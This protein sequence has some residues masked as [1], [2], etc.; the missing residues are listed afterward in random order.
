MKESI[1]KDMDDYIQ[2]LEDEDE[3]NLKVCYLNQIK[4]TNW[5]FFKA[6]KKKKKKDENAPAGTEP[7]QKKDDL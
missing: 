6:K 4:W 5:C 3:E 1:G 7:G 2:L